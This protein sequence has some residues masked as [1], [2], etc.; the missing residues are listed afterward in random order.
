G[1]KTSSFIIEIIRT[2]QQQAQQFRHD[3]HGETAEK[4]ENGIERKGIVHPEVFVQRNKKLRCQRQ[5]QY[6]DESDPQL[7][8]GGRTYQPVLIRL[9]FLRAGVC[10]RL[11]AHGLPPTIAYSSSRTGPLK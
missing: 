1:G 10:A 11:S 6:D 5:Q 4:T 3:D 8:Y 7:A 9:R 2:L